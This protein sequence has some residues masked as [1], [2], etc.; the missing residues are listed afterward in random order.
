MF[1]YRQI[2]TYTVERR[3]GDHDSFAIAG[4]HVLGN[5]KIAE[6]KSPP[7]IVEAPALRTRLLSTKLPV[8]RQLDLTCL[9]DAIQDTLKQRSGE[10][11]VRSQIWRMPVRISLFFL[12]LNLISFSRES[13]TILTSSQRML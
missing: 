6:H 9:Q 1:T 11:S 5:Y 8:D 12:S 2:I 3:N 4:I 7:F 10:L 13:R